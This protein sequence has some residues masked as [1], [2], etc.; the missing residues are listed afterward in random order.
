MPPVKK[1]DPSRPGSK[2][3]DYWESAQHRLLKDPKKLL[4]DLLKYDKV[5]VSVASQSHLVLVRSCHSFLKPLATREI[6]WEL[7]VG[8]LAKRQESV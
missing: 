5:S 1:P 6:L 4:D 7:P 8:A 3:E 2:I